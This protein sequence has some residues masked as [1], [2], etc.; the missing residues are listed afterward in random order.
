M[1]EALHAKSS[2]C[3]SCVPTWVYRE[4]RFLNKSAQIPSLYAAIPSESNHHLKLVY[5]VRK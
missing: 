2:T 1:N 3:H 4:L 5:V